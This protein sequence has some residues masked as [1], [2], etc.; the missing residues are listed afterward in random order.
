MA[1]GATQKR[2]TS[3]GCFMKNIYTFG[4]VSSLVLGTGAVLALGAMSA[5]AQQSQQVRSS[6]W[7]KACS[8]Q[9]E[10]KICNVQF[11][12][13]ASTGQV[14][15]S[16]NLAEI[17]GQIKRRVFQITVPTGRLIPPGIKVQIDGKKGAAIPYSFCTPRT[18]AAEVALDDTLVG[19]LK[20]GGE[21]D[22]V[23]TNFQGKEN[24]IKITLKGF[25]AAYDGPPI[26]RDELQKSQE[27]LQ[28]ELQEKAEETRKKLL[29]AQ[30]AAT[31]NSTE[32]TASE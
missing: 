8:D 19:L 5:N 22:V 32:G 6:G 31:E 25:T 27:N 3:K 16:V 7:Y 17:T 18:C 26:K 24:P 30:K 13:L 14:I 15:T 20:A 12:A 4:A 9:G 10:S 23:S 28:K 11:Q 29:E 1:K 2:K 21:M